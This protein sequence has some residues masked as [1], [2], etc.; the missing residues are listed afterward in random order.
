[1]ALGG[2]M[3]GRLTLGVAWVLASACNRGTPPTNADKDTSSGVGSDTADTDADADTDTDT[4]ADTD[5]DTN[6]RFPGD[7]TPIDVVLEGEFLVGQD[8]SAGADVDGDGAA[9]LAIGSPQATKDYTGR[10]YIARGPLA[11]NVDLLTEASIVVEG[12][13]GDS[14]GT[15]VDLLTDFDGDGFGDLLVGAPGPTLE[16]ENVVVGRAYLLHGPIESGGLED[17]D[18]VFLGAR[19]GDWAGQTGAGVGDVNDDGLTDL[20]LGNFHDAASYGEFDGAAYLVLGGPASGERSLQDDSDTVLYGEAKSLVGYWG[21]NLDGA[22]D[23]DGDGLD[24]LVIGAPGLGGSAYVVTDIPAGPFKLAAS[25]GIVRASSA[26]TTLGWTVAGVGDVD[27]DGF[28]DVALG[29]PRIGSGDPGSVHI[30]CGPITGDKAVD[31]AAWATLIPPNNSSQSFGESIAGGDFDGDGNVDLLIGA[32]WYNV[33][34]GLVAKMAGP[35]VSGTTSLVELDERDAKETEHFGASVTAGD[36]TGD[37][38]PEL[39]VGAIG[40]RVYVTSDELW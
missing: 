23:V 36:L 21:H 27:G 16:K 6:T 38:W 39:V 37:G 30:V 18:A 7:T 31:D 20:V 26:D 10:V 28:D 1:M 14:A 35:L 5:A 29:D 22:G 24:D 2:P 32:S 11:M 3:L 12:I 13:A 34:K 25:D 8:V 4:D 15:M 19:V 9:D 40:G 17:A 33:R